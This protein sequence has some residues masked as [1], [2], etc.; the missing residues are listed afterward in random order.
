MY[1]YIYIYIYVCMYVLTIQLVAPQDI[2]SPI[3]NIRVND[4]DDIRVGH[5]WYVGDGK[6]FIGKWEQVGFGQNP[7]KGKERVIN[8]T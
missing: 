3:S 7:W 6:K 5:G 4:I 2:I 8:I 1:P